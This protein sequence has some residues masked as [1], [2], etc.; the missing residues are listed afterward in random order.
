[1]RKPTKDPQLWTR[2]GVYYFRGTIPGTKKRIERKLG[3]ISFREAKQLKI[4]LILDLERTGVT[5]AKRF[6]EYASSYLRFRSE[7]L[8]KKKISEGT[9]YE[10]QL[11]INQHLV[12]FFGQY[13][14]D[15]IDQVAFNKYVKSQGERDFMN[16]RKVLSHFFSWTRD[17]G[18]TKYNPEFK[19]PKHKRKK[20]IVLTDEEAKGLLANSPE[21]L[22]LF[23]A[24]A[25]FMGMRRS[26]I[27]KLTWDRVDLENG[28][29]ELGDEDTKIRRGRVIPL[30]HYV[31]NSLKQLKRKSAWVFPNK[32]RNGTT[33]HM[34]VAG[35]RRPWERA[36]VM[37]GIS[38]DITPHDLRATWETH[39]HLNPSFTSTMVEKMAGASIDVQKKIYVSLTAEQLRP[40][41]E[42][43]NI[44]GLNDIL[45]NGKTGENRGE[46]TKIDDS[47]NRTSIGIQAKKRNTRRK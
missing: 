8:K 13:T 12:P 35:F 17:E 11:I 32:R 2:G 38:R 18:I 24:F 36:K 45:N 43:V 1:M 19:I 15:K 21:N 37:A 42:A 28:T 44:E 16:H 14:L 6:K 4:Q 46:T 3:K 30:N 39:A 23:I 20:R 34:N 31:W 47:E 41:S 25:L 10:S 33:G 7:E 9:Y 26:E 22:R 29:L 27:I 5:N 40:L